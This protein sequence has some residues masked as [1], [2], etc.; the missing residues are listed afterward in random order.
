MT[1]TQE[2]I[3]HIRQLRSPL[4]PIPTGMSAPLT[5]LSGIRAVLFDVYGTLVISGSGDISV[6][7]AMS[8]QQAVA[9]ALHWAGFSGNLAA[10]GEQGS[11]ALLDAIRQTHARQRQA[12]KDVPEVEIRE[13][14][15]TVLTRL[16]QN[17][18]IDGAITP[19]TLARVSLDY[20]CR[21]NPVWPMPAAQ[22][23]LQRL[24]ARGLRLGIVSN[25][26]FYTSLLFP[27]LLG[28]TLDEFGIEPLMCA[29]SFELREAK[30]SVNLFR[31]VVERL[32]QE[33]GIAP[34]ETVY[35]GND[36]LNDLWTA[37]QLGLKT[38]LFAGDQR[39]LRLRP[40]DPRCAALEPEIILTTLAQLLEVV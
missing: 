40:D 10:A 38:A 4:E 12:G 31:S 33:Y 24:H 28:H 1:L 15:Q 11:A 36:M 5:L 8:D 14:W 16:Q 7:S 20:E 29:W 21:V 18:L 34:A 2:F 26:Q 30:P 23:T 25:A 27:A 19:E 17:G 32:Q 37:R 9:E 22:A 39:S 35:V 6:A 13:E 3:E